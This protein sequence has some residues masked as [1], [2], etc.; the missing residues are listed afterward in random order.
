MNE[1]DVTTHLESR[2]AA[3]AAA[4]T[5]PMPVAWPNVHFKP[6]ANQV[7]VAAHHLRAPARSHDLGG[8]HRQWGGI[9]QI[10]VSLPAG[11]GAAAAGQIAAELETVFP[12]VPPRSTAQGAVVTV[13]QPVSTGPVLPDGERTTVPLSVRYTAQVYTP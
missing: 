13:L 7:F 5:P 11:T 4:R 2:L 9:F 12:M 6:P 3:W 8:Q 10:T 1:L